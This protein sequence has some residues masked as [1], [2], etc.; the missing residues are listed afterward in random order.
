MNDIFTYEGE[1]VDLSQTE[2]RLDV[3]T[4]LEQFFQAGILLS[5]TNL[6]SLYYYNPDS[7]YLLLALIT[8]VLSG[9]LY[10][11]VDCTYIIDNHKYNLDY[12]RTIFGL[13]Q[14]YTVCRFDEIQCVSS[15]ASFI[16][17]KD[18]SYY[19]HHVVIILKTGQIFKVSNTW[20]DSSRACNALAK[21]LAAH[22]GVKYEPGFCEN[23]ISTTKEPDGSGCLI[24]FDPASRNHYLILH[25]A[26]VVS[27]ILVIGHTIFRNS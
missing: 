21:M 18:S 15:N 22:F 27:I 11:F 19:T 1:T 23:S 2:C 3:D 20:K 24:S 4:P 12:S 9:L 16:Y 10:K 8:L 25:I 17:Q 6:L 5:A 26:I 7:E 14:R 13:E